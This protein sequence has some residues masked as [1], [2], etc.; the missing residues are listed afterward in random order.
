VGQNRLL[1]VK[2]IVIL[3][4]SKSVREHLT[5]LL[6]ERGNLVEAASSTRELRSAIGRLHSVS[7]F[8]VAA[9]ADGV[10]P[11][12][13]W[14]ELR[15]R[16]PTAFIFGIAETNTG[17]ARAE[18]LNWGADDCIGRPI[19][20]S[21]LLARIDNLLSRRDPSTRG[22]IAAVGNTSVKT[23][24]RYIEVDGN[25]HQLPAKEFALLQC[26]IQMPGRVFTRDELLDL[27]WGVK[28]D[29]D[30]NVLE[31]TVSNLR[32]RLDKLGSNLK[33]RNSRNLGYWV[34][35]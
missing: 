35:K 6:L 30:T 9:G 5:E 29:I 17:D 28:A 16:W 24:F 11:R 19:H 23:E 2:T 14:P 8:L 22:R 33:V 32:K 3:E 4:P 20:N 21:E 26:L 27:I 10:E 12:K 7:M 34:E 13:L 31:V 18:A 25:T 1:N 15:N